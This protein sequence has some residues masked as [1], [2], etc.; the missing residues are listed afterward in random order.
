MEQ[1]IDSYIELPFRERSIE[2]DLN[3]KLNEYAQQLTQKISS[4]RKR[5]EVKQCEFCNLSYRK[6]SVD[7]KKI[8]R[9]KSEIAQLE[10]E[11][12]TAENELILFW[13]K[14]SSSSNELNAIDI[15]AIHESAK[16]QP[17]II[18]I[19]PIAI[20]NYYK[21]CKNIINKAVST[22]SEHT[23]LN[24]SGLIKIAV[25]KV[26]RIRKSEFVEVLISADLDE[27]NQNIQ[28]HLYDDY[29][30]EEAVTT[31]QIKISKFMKVDLVS[32]NFDVTP[33]STSIQEIESKSVGVWR[34]E[35]I[36][37]TLGEQKI[38][39]ELWAVFFLGKNREKP[40]KLKAFTKK[41]KVKVTLSYILDKYKAQ[42]IAI[43]IPLLSAVFLNWDKI[44]AFLGI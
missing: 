7:R 31:E 26:M 29:N 17:A 41:I 1:F 2:S 5:I 12:Q 15:P 18:R 16:P 25:N 10:K 30:D 40:V 38:S 33:Q 19:I 28:N 11:L 34:W 42:I 43:A 21:Q 35:I 37:K 23:N 6:R 27:I 3:S 9:L 13:F 24:D 39:V 14:R 20:S 22:I 44:K 32:K 36:P 8:E 4:I